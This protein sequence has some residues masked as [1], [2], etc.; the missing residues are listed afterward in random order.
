MEDRCDGFR[1]EEWPP[2]D[3]RI[4]IDSA[5]EGAAAY[6]AVE[7]SVGVGQRERGKQ[8]EVHDLAASMCRVGL[9]IA[10]YRDRRGFPSREEC[11]RARAVQLSTSM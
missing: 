10:G 11:Q 3:S 8:V 6:C 9:V 7:L 5:H 4:V 1:T 2:G